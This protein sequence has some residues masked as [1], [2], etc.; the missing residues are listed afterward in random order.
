MHVYVFSV[1]VTVR[2]DNFNYTVLEE[3]KREQPATKRQ[4]QKKKEEETD[5]SEGKYNR[6]QHDRGRMEPKGRLRE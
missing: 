1:C 5:V 6:R 2:R 3:A 4:Q